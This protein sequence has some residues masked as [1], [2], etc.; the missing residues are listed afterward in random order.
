MFYW[1]LLMETFLK[2][3]TPMNDLR[4]NKYQTIIYQH[5]RKVQRTGAATMMS[6]DR[7]KAK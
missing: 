5:E 1:V 6:H 7:S 3:K 2:S 4:T